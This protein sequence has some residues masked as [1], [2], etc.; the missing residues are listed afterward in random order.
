MVFAGWS[1]EA[2]EFFD[3]DVP[4]FT[5]YRGILSKQATV[6]AI[7]DQNRR[8]GFAPCGWRALAA[9]FRHQGRLIDLYPASN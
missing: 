5:A 4:F 9:A 3:P 7:A 1:D 6:F 8:R 2:I